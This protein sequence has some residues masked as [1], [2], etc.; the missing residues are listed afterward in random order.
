MPVL[1]LGRSSAGCLGEG[2]EEA[3]PVAFSV[4]DAAHLVTTRP[5]KV[6][7]AMLEFDARSVLAVGDEAQLELRLQ[8]RVVLP[9][10]GDPQ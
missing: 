4:K 1:G 7:T 10:R 3:A 9:V 2:L 6:E 5:V 8:I